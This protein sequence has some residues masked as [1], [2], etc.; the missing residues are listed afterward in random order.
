MTEIFFCPKCEDHMR[1]DEA[2]FENGHF[3]CPACAT[4]LNPDPDIKPEEK[5]IFKYP[6]PIDDEIVLSMPEGAEVLSVQVQRGQ[7]CIWAVVNPTR[8]PVHH[9]FEIR[10]TGHRFMGNEGRFIGSFQL[11][12]GYLIFHLFERR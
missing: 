11:E 10:G 9:T 4:I 2:L 7:P 3:Y 5:K 12:N 8:P 1:D 6:I